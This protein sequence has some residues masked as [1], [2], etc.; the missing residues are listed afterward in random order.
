MCLLAYHF[1][2]RKLLI[3]TYSELGRSYNYES[4]SVQNYISAQNIKQYSFAI[5][6]KQI[7]KVDTPHVHVRRRQCTV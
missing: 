5:S 4:R 6:H 1:R 3:L 7:I 2:T